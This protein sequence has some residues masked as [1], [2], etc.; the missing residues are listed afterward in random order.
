LGLS[1]VKPVPP[2]ARAK[3]AKSIGARS[4]EYYV[5]TPSLNRVD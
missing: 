4:Q 2:H 1:I 5:H 3:P